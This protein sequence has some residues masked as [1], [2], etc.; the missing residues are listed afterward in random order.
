VLTPPLQSTL[1][2]SAGGGRNTLGK[3]GLTAPPRS[4]MPLLAQRRLAVGHTSNPP[5]VLVLR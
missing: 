4:G 1:P 3:K 2:K 5:L